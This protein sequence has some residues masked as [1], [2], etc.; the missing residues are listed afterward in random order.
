[1]RR[2]LTAL[3]LLALLA[4]CGPSYQADDLADPVGRAFSHLYARG[5]SEAGRTDVTAESLRT[6]TTCQRG[7]GDTLDEGPGD[8]WRCLVS[9]TD[10]AM[11]AKQVLYEVVLKPDG[12]F[13]A[14][15]PPAVVGDARVRHADGVSRL[16]PI[17]AFDGCLQPAP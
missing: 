12:C 13:S 6:T 14:D 3:P 9:F 7:G 2:A 10:P 15:G 8:D 11:G 1:M 4:G 16:N 5:E 17:Y